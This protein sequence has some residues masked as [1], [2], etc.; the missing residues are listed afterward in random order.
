MF[1]QLVTVLG[2]AVEIMGVQ[3]E[4]VLPTL[5]PFVHQLKTLPLGSKVGR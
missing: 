3:H 1:V 4:F 5:K 2:V